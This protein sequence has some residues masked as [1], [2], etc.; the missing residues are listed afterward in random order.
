MANV[1]ARTVLKYDTP[2]GE[3]INTV[4]IQYDDAVTNPTTVAET[5]RDAFVNNVLEWLSTSVV[6]TEV[7][8]GD[9]INGGVAVSGD[10]GNDNDD[11]ANPSVCFMVTKVATNGRNGRWFLPGV[12]EGA[13]DSEG[14]IAI[15]KVAAIQ[16]GLNQMYLDVLATGVIWK[17]RNSLGTDPETY[18]Y[19]NIDQFLCRTYMAYLS[20][21]LDR[22]RYG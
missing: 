4:D 16:S 13:V 9:D 19:A 18:T 17:I 6:L 12:A 11:V 14:K 15:T 22:G 7:Q 20:K 10:N 5:I 8:V 2:Y 1:I 3:A 21:R